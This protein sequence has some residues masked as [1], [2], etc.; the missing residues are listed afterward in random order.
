MK[1]REKVGKTICKKKQK[2]N[3]QGRVCG[4]VNYSVNV[5]MYICPNEQQR[6]VILLVYVLSTQSI[7]EKKYPDRSGQ[8]LPNTHN[9][10]LL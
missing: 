3:V 2:E 4:G 9:S 10:P 5:C 6:Y 8:A 1:Q 7:W